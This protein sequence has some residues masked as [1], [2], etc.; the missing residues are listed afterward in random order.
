MIF[1]LSLYQK[2]NQDPELFKDLCAYS[3]FMVERANVGGFEG[4]FLI[5]NEGDSEEGTNSTTCHSDSFLKTV[6]N[7]TKTLV[8]VGRVSEPSATNNNNGWVIYS[9]SYLNAD[10]GID[11]KVLYLSTNSMVTEET[12]SQALGKN[13][14]DMC[15]INHSP[16]NK[17]HDLVNLMMTTLKTTN[18]TP[19]EFVGE[20]INDDGKQASESLITSLSTDLEL[21]VKNN[22]DIL[23][24]NLKRN[25][26]FI[27]HFQKMLNELPTQTKEM[28]SYQQ[29]LSNIYGKKDGDDDDWDSSGVSSKMD[30]LKTLREN[31]VRSYSNYLETFEDGLPTTQQ[32]KDGE[33]AAEQDEGTKSQFEILESKYSKEM[34]DISILFDVFRLFKR[35]ELMNK[36][37]CKV[38]EILSLSLFMKENL[39]TYFARVVSFDD[40]GSPK[41]S[42]MSQLAYQEDAERKK[43]GSGR[44][45]T[46]VLEDTCP[47]SVPVETDASSTDAFGVDMDDAGFALTNFDRVLMNVSFGSTSSSNNIQNDDTK[48]RKWKECAVKVDDFYKKEVGTWGFGQIFEWASSQKNTQFDEDGTCKAIAILDRANELT[49][50]G[51]RLRDTQIV[52]ILAFIF[53][54]DDNSK[55]HMSQ[56]NTGEGKTTVVACVAA[57][58]VLQGSKVDILTSDMVLAAQGVDDKK[59]FFNTLSI[60]VSHNNVDEEY[61]N[62]PRTCYESD[63]VYGSI[64]NF[65]FDYLKHHFD[66]LKTLGNRITKNCWAILDEVDS[67]IIDQGGNVAKLSQPFPGM[68]GLRDVYINIWKAL[69]KAEKVVNLKYADSLKEKGRELE[70]VLQYLVYICLYSHFN[71]FKTFPFFFF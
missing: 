50:P 22:I 7:T 2:I 35:G 49:T 20:Y 43:R 40:V 6:V 16:L 53:F 64:S 65:Q 32:S 3:E 41:V 42:K 13:L 60:D 17:L 58:K 15:A 36:L 69:H 45:G 66:R 24:Q 56:I 34:G 26:A 47:I 19:F 61:V 62:G 55:G 4:K 37:L 5:L 57:L 31:A 12:I 21:V 39:L 29:E 8:I 9:S 38:A 71:V 59:R 68:E 67:L 1:D 28:L 18:M 46:G 51:H 63:V 70:Q 11:T 30:E 48:K 54:C 27:F 23:L 44:K 52:A 25:D 10:S 14:V 33:T